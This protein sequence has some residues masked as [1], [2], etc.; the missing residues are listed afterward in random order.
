M[1][2]W[3]AGVIAV[4]AIA[5]VILVRP[6]NDRDWSPDQARLP[7]AEFDGPLVTIRNVRNFQYLSTDRWQEGWYDKTLDLRELD[8]LWFI[9]EPFG[10]REGP[11]HTFLSFGFADRDFISISAEIRKEKGESFSALKGLLRQYEI[12]YVVGDERD[13]VKLRSNYRKDDVYL[14][15]VRTS[16]EKKRE[17]FVEMLTRANRLR[18]KPEFYNTLTNTCTTNIVR[19]VNGI[20]PK[21]IPMRIEVLLPGY[22]DRLAYELGLIDTDLPFDQL[23]ERFRINELALRFADDPEFS[24]RIRGL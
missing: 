13:L 19:H 6:S 5:F 22:S 9:V 7:V 24:R 3:A 16:A 8:S 15:P 23:R 4:V 21:K 1:V 12:M 17:L 14:Y 18:E 11:A 2:L 10:E 20:A